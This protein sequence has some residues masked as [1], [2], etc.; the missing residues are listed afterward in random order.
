MEFIR[1]YKTYISSSIVVL[2][3]SLLLMPFIVTTS[4]Y[5]PYVAGKGFYFRSIVEICTVLYVFLMLV[6]AEYRPRKSILL[7]T[8]GGLLAVFFVSNMLSP[9]SYKSFLSNYER[10]DGYINLVHLA[11]LFV[12]ATSVFT[13]KIWTWFWNGSLIIS[14]ATGVY[15]Y[16]QIVGNV[17]IRQG[18]VRVDGPFGNATYLAV[19]A[20]F[21]IGIALYLLVRYRYNLTARYAYTFVALVNVWM[22]YNTATRGAMLGLISGVFIAPVL[23]ALFK[24][25]KQSYIAASIAVGILVISGLSFVLVKNTHFVQ[26]HPVL[27]RF[28]NISFSDTTANSRLQIWRM[29]GQGVLDKPVF[30]WGQESFNFVFNTYYSPSMWSQEQWFDRTHNVILDWVVTGG[31]LGGVA[32]LGLFIV[33]LFYIIRNDELEYLEQIALVGLV[34]A[35]GVQN[36]FVF[37]N[38]VSYVYWFFILAFVAGY[39]NAQKIGADTKQ[40]QTDGQGS[41][42]I[43]LASTLLVAVCFGYTS[44]VLNIKPLVASQNLIAGLQSYGD[45]S[46]RQSLLQNISQSPGGTTLIRSQIPTVVLQNPNIPASVKDIFRPLQK[47]NPNDKLVDIVQEKITEKTNAV[48]SG[49]KTAIDLGT[50]GTAEVREQIGTLAGQ[51]IRDPNLSD[52]FK[53]S[54]AT[55]ARTQMT[56]HALSSPTDSRRQ[57]LAGSAFRQ[58]G[59]I[60]SSITFLE[61]AVELSP[62]KQTTILEL[63]LSYLLAGEKEKVLEETMYAYNLDTSFVEAEVAYIGALLYNG[64]T[65][66]ADALIQ[67]LTLAGHQKDIYTNSAFIY[68]LSEIKDYD[69]LVE[70]WGSRVADS[71]TDMNA[72]VSL[73]ASYY[74]QGNTSKA[75]ATIQKA[76]EQNPEFKTQGEQYIADIQAGRV[77]I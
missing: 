8:I 53:Q 45:I 63:S 27:S 41:E 22:L 11:L 68:V 43:L 76:I 47:G 29:A 10:M 77:S 12:I 52:E 54:F 51:V 38:P 2:L 17:A 70:V 35:Y 37:D 66:E 6:D 73:A 75:I 20:L 64:K 1:T 59:D 21:N 49:L 14:L 9:D 5:F 33:A 42:N 23:V 55:F 50:F 25:N 19:Y 16:N 30:G 40:Y 31:L 74:A 24:R 56:E 46:V 57:L 26:S 71:P 15:V 62:T 72:Y 39:S 32:Y 18:G 34:I 69:R 60:K 61:K 7:Y 3:F 48:L 28:A 44:Y 4:L 13:K 67:E 65:V 58:M 36:M